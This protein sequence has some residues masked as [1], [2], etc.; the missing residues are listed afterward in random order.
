MRSKVAVGLAIL[1]VTMS[2]LLVPGV[3]AFWW[4]PPPPKVIIP[5]TTKVETLTEITLTGTWQDYPISRD[6]CSKYFTV[7]DDIYGTITGTGWV[8]KYVV[9]L[10]KAKSLRMSISFKSGNT[11]FIKWLNGEVSYQG[12]TTDS[13]ISSYG[14]VSIPTL[15]LQPGTYEFL[16]GFIQASGAPVSY[17]L[18]L[19]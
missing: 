4:A 16:V 17:Q 13:W 12:G 19:G 11:G 2:V 7:G 14:S 1:A 15:Y 10:T 8:D 18:K 5:A 9:T 3:V 6:F